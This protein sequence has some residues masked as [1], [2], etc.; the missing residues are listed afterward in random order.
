MFAILFSTLLIAADPASAPSAPPPTAA[1]APAPAEPKKK[2]G[3][4][5]IC[6]D[7]RPTGSHV[8]TRMC[9]TRDEIDHARE[10]AK[11]ELGPRVNGPKNPFGPS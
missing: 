1:A 10:A 11:Q 2:N 9:A 4:E 7:E 3:A 6:W 5:R 8:T